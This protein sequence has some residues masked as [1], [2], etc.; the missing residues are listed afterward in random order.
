MSQYTHNEFLFEKRS[1][2]IDFSVDY[3]NNRSEVESMLPA[4]YKW[5]EIAAKSIS[6]LLLVFALPVFLVLG[7]IWALLC[8]TGAIGFFIYTQS[9]N[10]RVFVR[11]NVKSSELFYNYC[12]ENNVINIY[13]INRG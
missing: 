8:V 4:G 3:N 10:Y 1:R 13:E 6:I 2:R 11:A 5:S 12:V 9:F 7:W